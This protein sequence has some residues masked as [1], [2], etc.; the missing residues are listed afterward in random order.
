VTSGHGNTKY[1]YLED[2]DWDGTGGAI[3]VAS[4]VNGDGGH[5][6]RPMFKIQATNE[7]YV[8]PSIGG[9]MK[10]RALTNSIQPSKV[11]L[12]SINPTG[13]A[14]SI[15]SDDGNYHDVVLKF[16]TDG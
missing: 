16:F 3:S 9:D 6:L 2:T 5:S 10:T 8:P 11:T 12:A 14:Q 4:M 7:E 15:P 1:C 13:T